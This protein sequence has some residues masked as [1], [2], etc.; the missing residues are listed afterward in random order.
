MKLYGRENGVEEHGAMDAIRAAVEA[1]SPEA[2][3]R[4]LPTQYINRVHLSERLCESM[5]VLFRR[6]VMRRPFCQYGTLAQVALMSREPVQIGT[7]KGT[8]VDQVLG[9][10]IL[11]DGSV[12]RELISREP[13]LEILR[14]L[15]Y[16]L[17][18]M[19]KADMLQEACQE[20]FADIMGLTW[21]CW[22]PKDGK[23]C[24]QCNMCVER[25]LP[26]PTPRKEEEREEWV[27]VQGVC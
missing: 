2:G 22:H 15:R 6:G 17:L 21:S 16:P 26:A 10:D 11:E 13:E 3:R 1:H 27:T 24:G 25:I 20:G 23:A 7:E 14:N 9:R 19:S 5:Q 18:R 4:L 8:L 12:C